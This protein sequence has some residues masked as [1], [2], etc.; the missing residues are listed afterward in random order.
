MSAILKTILA[1]TVIKQG[2]S[3]ERRKRIKDFFPSYAA[4]TRGVFFI[5]KL[6]GFRG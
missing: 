4:T 5:Q 1:E 3:I 2:I 6:V